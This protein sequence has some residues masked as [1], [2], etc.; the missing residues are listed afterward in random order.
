MSRFT[1]HF[2]W[3]GYWFFTVPSQQGRDRSDLRSVWQISQDLGRT[4]LQLTFPLSI[5]SVLS[6]CPEGLWGIEK[7][8]RVEETGACCVHFLSDEQKTSEGHDAAV[9]SLV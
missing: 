4:V 9:P 3:P 1:V 2:W 8:R 7:S 5:R 6:G